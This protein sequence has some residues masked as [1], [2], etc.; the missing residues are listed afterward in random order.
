[1]KYM[2]PKL[3]ILVGY[4]NWFD[5][6]SKDKMIQYWY[7]DKPVII[8]YILILV[9]LIENVVTWLTLFY[10]AS[11]LQIFKIAEYLFSKID[12]KMCRVIEKKFWNVQSW[13][14]VGFLLI[15]KMTT[16]IYNT[17]NTAAMFFNRAL[18][19]VQIFVASNSFLS[20]GLVE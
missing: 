11:G 7:T 20:Q 9:I 6:D 18:Q 1:M 8:E 14:S 3:M 15:A 16:T 4:Q 12:D 17:S 5:D 19:H 2:Y 10:F 13:K